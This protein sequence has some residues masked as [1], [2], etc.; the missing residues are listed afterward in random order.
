M[1]PPVYTP[2]GVSKL[3]PMVSMVMFPLA[4]AV[5]VHHTDLPPVLPAWLGSPTS[6]VA[7]T[8]VPVR[9]AAVPLMLSRLAKLSFAGRMTCR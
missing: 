4:G 2:K 8:F 1:L 9:V 7:F 5:Q 3:L 6:F